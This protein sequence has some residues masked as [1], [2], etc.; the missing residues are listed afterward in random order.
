[1]NR[2][3]KVIKINGFR[4]VL[5]AIFVIGC[6]FAG[7]MIFPGWVFMQLWNYMASFFVAVPEMQLIHGSI[8]W[9]IVALMIYAINNS[10]S[11]I[12]ISSHP[13]LNEDQIKEIMN[14]VKNSA[15]NVKSITSEP[16]ENEN[17]KIESLDEIRK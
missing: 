12:G 5:T 17:N 16:S 11:L 15:N 8:L 13:T 7:F 2:N 3:L 1:M 14:K 10:R 6:L 4:G 9:T